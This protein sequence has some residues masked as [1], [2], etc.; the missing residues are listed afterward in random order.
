MLSPVFYRNYVNQVET[1]VQSDPTEFWKIINNKRR[2]HSDIPSTMTWD[3]L[4]AITGAEIINLFAPY[5]ESVYIPVTSD[6]ELLD[7]NQN[8]VS[9]NL[10]DFKATFDVVYKQ[11]MKLNPNKRAG[12][13]GIPKMFF[14]N[15]AAGLCEPITY[16]FNKSLQQGVF[17]TDW[18]ASFVCPIHKDS[19]RSSVSNYRPI[20]IQSSLAKLLEKVILPQLATSFN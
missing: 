7:V 11:L 10:D 12:P 18:K 9:A 4:S 3:N 5:F 1:L 15:C 19:S 14:R 6:N 20:C 13:D 8:E 2:S 17:P 16:V